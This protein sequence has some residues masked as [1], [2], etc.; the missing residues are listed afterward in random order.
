MRD[1]AR[2]RLHAGVEI[3]AG[4]KP[5]EAHLVRRQV[6][7]VMLRSRRPHS[8]EHR[9]V[10]LIDSERLRHHR[11]KP[12][13]HGRDVGHDLRDTQRRMQ[14]MPVQEDVS[15]LMAENGRESPLLR[16]ALLA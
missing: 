15:E 14:V 13:Q 8:A 10:V 9:L 16:R 5:Y 1:A 4:T 7:Q 2:D 12:V 6:S 3:E 11:A